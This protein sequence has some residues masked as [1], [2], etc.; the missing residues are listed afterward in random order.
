MKTYWEEEQEKLKEE[1]KIKK[2]KHILG[3]EDQL[4]KRFISYSLK[5]HSTPPE[6]ILIKLGY[7]DIKRGWT[8]K[9]NKKYRFHAFIPEGENIIYLHS[10]VLTKNF[11]HKATTHFVAEEFKRMKPFISKP[12]QTI[13]VAQRSLYIDELRKVGELNTRRKYNFWRRL[14]NA[15]FY[16]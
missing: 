9:I 11:M 16:E 14:K 10:D 4:P 3:R 13:E 15:I 12:I 2:I 8:K 6:E 7:K 1:Q 5:T